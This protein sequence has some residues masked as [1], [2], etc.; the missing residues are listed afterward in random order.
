MSET[1]TIKL[2]DTWAQS[3]RA[4]RMTNGHEHIY[5]AF[6]K[7]KKSCEGG[8]VDLGCGLGRALSY[9]HKA[10]YMPCIGVD[11]SKE[12]IEKA[13][14]LNK[15]SD[16]YCTDFRELPIEANSINQFFSVEALYYVTDPEAV[17]KECMRCLKPGGQIDLF[18]DFYEEN[19]SSH[20]WPELL[21]IE[22]NLM[23][24]TEWRDLI[25]QCGFKN[26][27]IDKVVDQ[28]KINEAKET[29]KASGS[30]PTKQSYIDFLSV[31]TLWLRGVKE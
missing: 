26:V 20:S 16:F 14:A 17:L 21:E 27:E 30:F 11:A 6:F 7:N 8:F 22:M 23:A 31:G 19:K 1:K 9:A 13:K 2:F 12:M 24:S 4:L 25:A 18:M 5:K 15:N 29:F 28:N 10:E 3:D